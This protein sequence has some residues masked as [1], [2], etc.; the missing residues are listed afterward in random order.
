MSIIDL[1]LYELQNQES[2]FPMDS[3]HS[4]KLPSAKVIYGDNESEEENTEKKLRKK[5]INQ[6]EIKQEDI[7]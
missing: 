2:I 1:Y 6:N 4:G 5:E 3:I 7:K